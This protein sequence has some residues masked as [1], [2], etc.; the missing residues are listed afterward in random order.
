MCVCAGLCTGLG[1]GGEGQTAITLWLGI[2]RCLSGCVVLR[3]GLGVKHLSHCGCVYVFEWI[4]GDMYRAG[5]QTAIT[6]WLGIRRCLSGCA[7]LL[8]IRCRRS[9]VLIP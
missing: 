2:H 8:C 9:H 7:G 4:C 6:L 1:E 5:G 3:T